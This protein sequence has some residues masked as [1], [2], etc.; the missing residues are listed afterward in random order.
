MLHI[1]FRIELSTK[2]TD[3]LTNFP[4]QTLKSRFLTTYFSVTLK[5]IV[6]TNRSFHLMNLPSILPERRYSI[7]SVIHIN[8]GRTE[9]WRRKQHT[10]LR[11]PYLL[12][13]R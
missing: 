12:K 9:Y 13:K 8:C 5:T 3:G 4:S 10:S 6:D 11:I 2:S 7:E 1:L